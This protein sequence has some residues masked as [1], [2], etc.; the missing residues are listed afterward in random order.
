M[1]NPFAET[2]ERLTP[3]IVAL[4]HELHAYPE[5]RFEEYWTS[6]RIARFLDEAAIPY[7][8]GYARGTGI[9][10]TLDGGP[11]P[12]LALRT[13]IDGLE[14]QEETGLPYASTVPGRMHACGHDG[15]MA[16]LLGA[17]RVLAEHRDRLKGRVRFIFQPA[18]ELGGGARLMVE[19]GALNGV[20]AVFGLH[21]WPMMPV[22]HIGLRAGPIMATARFFRIEVSGRGA[23][24]ADPAAAV[25]P[26]ITVAHLI[27]ALQT[28]TSRELDPFEAGVVTV[29]RV[30]AGTASNIIPDVA[31]MEGTIRSLTVEG[32]DR[33]AESVSRIVEHTALAF[34]ASAD[35]HFGSS[36]YPPT[37]N[38]AAMTEFLAATA[39]E[40]LGV[41]SVVRRPAPSMTAE[42]F[43]FYL[44]AV[45]G[46]FF[47]LGNAP[48]DGRAGTPLHNARFDFND[49]A[50]P[51][52]MALWSHLVRRFLDRRA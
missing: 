24:G 39:E 18:E 26:I 12:T 8:R 11:G 36:A 42:D 7:Q 47:W 29:G 14:V 37:V 43:A 38:D 35:V 50:I 52:A 32:A 17:A 30:Q 51:T 49:K 3:E 13:D 6:D 33:I 16:C 27:T 41:D 20:D 28:V 25:D 5:I 31:V 19:E 1:A 45:P 46:V 22:G 40:V 10:A 9:V 15:H 21:A 44:Q 2:I 23:H 4:R 34:R 48:R